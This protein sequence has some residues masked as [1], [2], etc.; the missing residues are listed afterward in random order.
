[1]D[2]HASGATR[3]SM[4]MPTVSTNRNI[5]EF[6]TV[7]AARGSVESTPQRFGSLFGSSSAIQSVYRMIEKVSPSDASVL[8]VGESGSGKELVA[9]TIHQMSARASAPFVAVNCGAIPATLIEAE[10]FGHV[11]GAF[12][13]ATNTRKGH[14]ERARE[15]T[16]MLDEITEM[17]P[18]M[19]VRLLRVL[20]TG[21][22][23]RV[24]GEEELH[25]DVRV[26]AATNRDPIAAVREGR[27]R[28][29]LYYRLA[30]FPLRVPPLRARSGDS[31]RLAHHFLAGLNEVAGTAKSLS[32]AALI[33]LRSHAWPGNVR[34]LKN[35]I[36]RAFIL[37]DDVIQSEHLALN[38]LAPMTAG[39]EGTLRFALGTSLA[40]MEKQAILATLGHC[41]G[42]KRRCAEMLGVSLKTLYNRLTA[43]RCEGRSNARAAA[44]G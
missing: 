10:L 39:G 27:L 6:P 28:E 22:F 34:E 33:A 44:I 41:D 40:E 18:E 20:E 2:P 13:G 43:Y 32:P 26:I 42:H 38:T 9:N 25:A 12:T 7:S 21:R 17:Q 3:I 23:A 11:K 8:I 35:A 16:L 14:F 31:E 37:A 30:V 1:M 4:D 15:G 5:L 29:D 36:Q 24:G 19:Q